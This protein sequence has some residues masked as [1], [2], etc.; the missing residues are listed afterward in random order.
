MCGVVG[1]LGSIDRKMVDAVA[2]R[3]HVA[4][5]RRGI[6]AYLAAA[7]SRSRAMTD[8]V[9]SLGHM[10]TGKWEFDR[11]VTTV[12]DDMIERSIPQ[13]RAMREVVGTLAL[14]FG[15]KGGVVLDLGCSTG[16]S[17]QSLANDAR[18][19][20]GVEISESMLEAA[21]TRFTSYAN[22]EIVALDLRREF[23][24]VSDVDVELSIFTLQFIPVEHRRRVVR[25]A[26]QAL[27]PGGAL[28]V[29]EK[30]IG[31]DAAAQ[32]TFVDVYHSFKHAQGYTLEEIERKALALEGALVANTAAENESMLEASG[33]SSV[34]CV[35]RWV[36]FAAWLAIK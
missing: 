18:K 27:K 13:Y 15:A 6:V 29:A 1:G 2:H 30:V 7:L 31:R 34:E 8:Q 19:I 28:I 36:N 25:D 23:P 10:P 17:I 24:K 33:F 11:S 26:Y 9:S 3:Y 12:F 21:R 4:R 5:S 32:S 22:V 20:V 16:L 14:R 35:W